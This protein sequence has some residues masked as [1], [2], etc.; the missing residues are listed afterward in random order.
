MPILLCSLG[1][2]VLS[3][4]SCCF[5][6]Q[7]TFSTPTGQISINYHYFLLYYFEI[8]LHVKIHDAIDHE[9]YELKIDHKGNF[10]TLVQNL[11]IRLKPNTSIQFH[12]SLHVFGVC[13][14]LQ[15]FWRFWRMQFF[16]VPSVNPMNFPVFTL[17]KWCVSPIYLFSK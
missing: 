15:V 7:L 16:I 5:L 17:N 3:N 4:W 10:S 2:W 8:V 14:F 12:S 9:K 13:S 6:C 11:F 1:Y